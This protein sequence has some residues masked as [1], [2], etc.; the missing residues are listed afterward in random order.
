[1]SD[2]N[3]VNMT[4]TRKEDVKK[5]LWYVENVYIYQWFIIGLFLTFGIHIYFFYKGYI[6]TSIIYSWFIGIIFGYAHSYLRHLTLL[7]KPTIYA[8]AFEAERLIFRH[9]VRAFKKFIRFIA[10]EWY[11]FVFII[12]M[13]IIPAFIASGDYSFALF[14]LELSV[15]GIFQY[16]FWKYRMRQEINK[17]Y[18]INDER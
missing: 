8:G 1:M 10:Y 13:F 18:G 6:A 3:K 7:K 9:P 16:I 15:Y 11:F 17:K 14:I 12:I 4:S 5:A 2:M